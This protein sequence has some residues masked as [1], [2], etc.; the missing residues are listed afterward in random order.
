MP[1]AHPMKKS[2]SYHFEGL[3][4]HLTLISKESLRINSI[5]VDEPSNDNIK[6]YNTAILIHIQ[7]LYCWFLVGLNKYTSKTIF[8]Q[9]L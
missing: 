1:F 5:H 8:S 7:I 3:P 6:T 4:P 9:K 2:G